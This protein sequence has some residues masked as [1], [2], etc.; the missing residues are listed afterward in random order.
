MAPSDS[1]LIVSESSNVGT[2]FRFG[3]PKYPTSEAGREATTKLFLEQLVDLIFRFDTL[4]T[5]ATVTMW[6]KL[7]KDTPPE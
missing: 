6:I 7:N 3:I 1:S 4:P 2:P 5:S